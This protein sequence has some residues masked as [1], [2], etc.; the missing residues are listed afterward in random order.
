M[1]ILWIK[2]DFLHPTTRG[3]QIRTLEMLRRLHAR[4]EVVYVGFSNDP[5]GEGVARSK[6]Y[7][8]RAY[9]I[10][11]SPPPRRSLRFAGQLLRGL[12]DPLPVSQR[13]YVSSAM[14]AKIAQ[15]TRETRFDSVVCDFLAPAPNLPDLGASVLFQHNVETAIW[16]R[17]ADTAPNPVARAYFRQQASRMFAYERKV[18]RTVRHVIAVSPEDA[19]QFK[20]LFGLEGP[21]SDVPTGVDAGFFTPPAG[22]SRPR[23]GIVFVGS[24]DWMPNI[25]GVHFFVESILPLIRRAHPGCELIIA[26]RDPAPAIRQLAKSA[27]GIQVTGTVPDIRPYLWNSAISVV[28]LR[29][30]GG[31]RLKIYESMAAGAPVVSTSIGAEGLAV[32][33]G[34]HILLADTPEAFAQACT[35]LLS[36]AQRSRR[37]AEAAR[38]LVEERF[39]WD[40]VALGMEQIL[41]RYA[42]TR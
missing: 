9:A 13:R 39:S 25:D 20:K 3:G 5:G 6:E 40:Q 2:T 38:A 26:G 16:R 19:C 34:E 14:R 28:P 42:I 11:H 1:K 12:A 32:K 4:N 17:H 7:S 8:S 21:V 33:P 23:S 27:S 15:L 31:T 30:G 41:S 22:E 29:I 37:Q 36:D 35:G 10:L 24:M 18:C